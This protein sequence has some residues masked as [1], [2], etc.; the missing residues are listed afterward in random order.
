VP[1]TMHTKQFVLDLSLRVCVCVCE[2]ILSVLR[3]NTYKEDL[4]GLSL[5]KDKSSATQMSFYGKHICR[6]F[7]ELFFID[8]I[9]LR[10]WLYCLVSFLN[11]HSS[12]RAARSYNKQSVP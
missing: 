5:I 11:G 7:V 6:F 9:L 3:M 4:I 10:P 1:L 12:E 8:L 2:Y